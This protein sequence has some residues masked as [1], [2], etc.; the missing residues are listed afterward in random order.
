MRRDAGEGEPP[1]GHARPLDVYVDEDLLRYAEIW[2]AG[3]TPNAVFP[4][5]PDEL[6]RV[7]GADG[8]EDYVRDAQGNFD[9]AAARIVWDNPLAQCLGKVCYHFC[10]EACTIG[11]KGEPIAIRQIKRAALE[12]GKTPVPYEPAPKNGNGAHE[13]GSNGDLK[14]KA[15]AKAKTIEVVKSVADKAEK[16]GVTLGLENTLSAEQNLEIVEKIAVKRTISAQTGLRS[17]ARRSA[18]TC[19]VMP[20]RC[21]L[22]T[23]AR[24]SPAAPGQRRARCACPS[25]A[26]AIP[27]PVVFRNSRR[28]MEADVFLFLT[29]SPPSSRGWV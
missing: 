27:Q 25:E 14:G 7:A 1:V 17:T 21:T 8:Q 28:S 2:A 16:A 26:A 19:S 4:L 6:L 20:G 3:G 10:E 11:K 23:T 13:T 12:Y 5:T 18:R 29:A 22:T 24:A 9:E 15:D